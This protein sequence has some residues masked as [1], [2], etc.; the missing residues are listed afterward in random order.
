MPHPS[1]R[2]NGSRE[3]APDDKIRD[4]IHRAARGRM[5]FFVAYAPRNDGGYAAI[6]QNAKRRSGKIPAP[7]L[8]LSQTLR[9]VVAGDGLDLEVFFQAV[10]APL[11][12]VA[13]LLVTAERSGAVV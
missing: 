4:A 11:A 3:R 8:L 2:A 10:F 6:L 13:G 7:A 5:D 1:L 9:G 12:A